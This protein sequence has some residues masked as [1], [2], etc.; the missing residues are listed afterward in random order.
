[1]GWLALIRSTLEAIIA[2]PQIWDRFL[3]SNINAR[4]Q[5]LEEKV[6]KVDEAYKLASKAKTTVEKLNAATALFDSW[7]NP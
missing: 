2:I 3:N 7:G 4:L 1:M 6:E 5:R